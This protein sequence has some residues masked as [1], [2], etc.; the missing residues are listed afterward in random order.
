MHTSTLIAHH[1][2]YLL[3]IIC[4]R[5]GGGGVENLRNM[6]IVRSVLFWDLSSVEW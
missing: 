5:E 2:A 3:Y 1:L 4:P 6:R